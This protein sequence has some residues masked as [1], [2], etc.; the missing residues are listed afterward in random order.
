MVGMTEVSAPLT[1]SAAFRRLCFAS[2]C[3]AA[4]PGG[5]EAPAVAFDRLD[6]PVDRGGQQ[7]NEQD[8]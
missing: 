7:A 6:G 8:N 5:V 1:C 2:P 4:P 3:A